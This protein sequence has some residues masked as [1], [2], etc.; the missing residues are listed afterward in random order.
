M[1]IAF[2][3]IAFNI[4]SQV[5][6]AIG[7]PG[8]FALMMVESIGIP[9]LPSEFILP[10]AGIAIVADPGGEVGFL[11]IPFTWPTVLLASLGG[12]LAGATVAYVLGLRFG[13]PFLRR[14]GRRLGVSEADIDRAHRYFQSRGE[15]TVGICRLLPLVRAYIS[16]PAGAAE[17]DPRRFEAFTLL[18]SI[19]FT[20][21]LVYAG[22][23]LG[24]NLGTLESIFHILDIV[25]GVGL[26]VFV[27]AVL[28]KL[29]VRSKR[30]APP[31]VVEGPPSSGTG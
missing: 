15:A 19:P 1:A 31:P 27:L 20:V 17:M 14:I 5:I 11:G 18:G 28:W 9:P 21:V 13:I 29:H 24:Y 26:V 16:Y 8:L 7:I 22:T 23:I 10:L 4:V 2:T 6:Q 12:S 30:A 3:E 25:V